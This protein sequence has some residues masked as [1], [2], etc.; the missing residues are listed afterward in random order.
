MSTIELT[1]L[2]ANLLC[3]VTIILLLKFSKNYYGKPVPRGIDPEPS[4][5]R[6]DA[7]DSDYTDAALS[8]PTSKRI[9]HRIERFNRWQKQTSLKRQARYYNKFKANA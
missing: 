7:N 6:S 9:K 4:S 5:M 8:I 2:I 1:V 3:L